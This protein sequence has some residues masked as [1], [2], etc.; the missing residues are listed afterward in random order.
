[1]ATEGDHS[2][3]NLLVRKCADWSHRRIHYTHIN[4]L[5]K[6]P[7]TVGGILQTRELENHI[8][9]FLMVSFSILEAYY[10]LLYVIPLYFLK[11][12]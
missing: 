2:R 5:Y 6:S 8:Y 4:R 1:M 3:G 7:I 12:I 9:S 10:I 11:F